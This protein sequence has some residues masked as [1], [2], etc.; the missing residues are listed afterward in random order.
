MPKGSFKR[1]LEMNRKMSEMLK[2]RIFSEEHRKHLSESRKGK[3]IKPQCGFQKGVK[4][5]NWKGGPIAIICSVCGNTFK[6]PLSFSGHKFCSTVCCGEW[7]RKSRLG[8]NNPSWNGGKTPVNQKE[9]N[10][11]EYREWRNL[12]FASNNY[13][14]QI[15][16]ARGGWNKILKERISLNAHHLKSWSGYTNL[17]L[18]NNNGITLC[19]DCHKL[20]HWFNKNYKFNKG[21]SY[22]QP[23]S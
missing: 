11:K 19:S 3:P 10:A 13:T 7:M 5:W 8:K 22:E 14:C 12:I 1:T 18:D 4:H 15:C 6:V 21:L 16:G 20:V 9:R 2:G 23:K 17:R